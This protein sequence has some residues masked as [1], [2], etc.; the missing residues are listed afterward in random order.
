MKAGARPPEGVC[1][2]LPQGQQR[3]DRTMFCCVTIHVTTFLPE[4]GFTSLTP[5]QNKTTHPGGVCETSRI[6]NQ[7]QLSDI[8]SL[9]LL[10]ARSEVSRYKQMDVKI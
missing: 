2:V 10:P 7:I 3:E 4:A 1:A 5:K 6:E 9:N 8:F